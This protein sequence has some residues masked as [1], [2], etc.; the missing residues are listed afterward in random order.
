M[1]EINQELLEQ[2]AIES[3]KLLEER[4]WCAW[5]CQILRGEIIILVNDE[6]HGPVELPPGKRYPVYLLSEFE[7]VGELPDHTI[8]FIYFI[9]KHSNATVMWTRKSTEAEKS[10][11]IKWLGKQGGKLF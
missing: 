6:F 11:Y 8:R 1:E 10:E 9:K 7:K 4:G 2:T 5:K 3:K